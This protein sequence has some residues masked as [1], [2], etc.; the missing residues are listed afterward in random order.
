V[1][2]IDAGVTTVFVYDVKGQSIAEYTTATPTGGDT[3]YSITDHLGSTR[4][5]TDSGRN[6]KARYD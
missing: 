6:V 4:V 2:K 3:S 5:V 1:K